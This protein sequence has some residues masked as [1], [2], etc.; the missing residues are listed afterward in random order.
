MDVS[1]LR[2]FNNL[3]LGEPWEE[4]GQ[5][6]SY[7]EAMVLRG[8]YIRG[9]VPEGVL[10]TTL[11]C[12][13]QQNPARIECELLGHGLNRKKW[14]IDY[15]IVEGATHDADQGAFLKLREMI[16]NQIFPVM[17]INVFIDAGYNTTVVYDFCQGST[18]IHPIMGAGYI[19]GKMIRKKPITSHGITLHELNTDVYK[20]KLYDS[21]RLRK[22]EEGRKPNGYI[23][24]PFD[25]NTKYFKQLTSERRNVKIINGI[26]TGFV[27]RKKSSGARNEALD[28]R[29]YAM[30]AFDSIVEDI[31]E[32]AEL[33]AVNHNFFWEWAKKNFNLLI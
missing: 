20:Q 29:V 1:K 3:R 16:I 21:M 24:F 4:R 27:W 28:V 23:E 15:Y 10:L 14:S 5:G 11:G 9:T 17:P 31:C 19:K 8:E 18:G 32:A 6:I 12:D 30:A 2:S 33:D 13:V 26:R 22:N 25:Y 7:E